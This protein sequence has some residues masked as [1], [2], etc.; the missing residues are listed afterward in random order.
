MI[1]TTPNKYKPTIEDLQEVCNTIINKMDDSRTKS[2]KRSRKFTNWAS[3]IDHPCLRFLVYSRTNWRDRK[4]APADK[5][6]MF[7]EGRDGEKKLKA[8]IE[9]E[10][11]EVI[12]EQQYFDWNKY[13]ISGRTDGSLQ[14]EIPEHNFKGRGPLEIKTVAPHLFKR[15]TTIEEIKASKSYWVRKAVSQLN[16]YML[17]AGAEFG[18]LAIKTYRLRPRILPMLVDYELGEKCLKK[19]EEVNHCVAKGI[20]PDRIPYDSSICDIC[21]F[22]HLCAPVKVT[23]YVDEIDEQVAKD[24]QFWKKWNEI[25]SSWKKIAESLRKR[26]KGVNTIA[27]GVQISSH[28]HETTVYDWPEEYKKIYGRKEIRTKVTLDILEEN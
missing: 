15:M 17:M 6:Y 24:L 28:D 25:G 3:E 10:G 18:F 27:E 11:Y 5:Q 14:F 21:D 8:M 7:E 1:Q 13:E 4:L 22:D 20:Q 19:C 9:A 16:I 26:L 2:R 12:L 23:K